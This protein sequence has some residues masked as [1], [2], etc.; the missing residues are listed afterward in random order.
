MNELTEKLDDLNSAI[1][2]LKNEITEA[3]RE[4]LINIEP[5]NAELAGVKR[6]RENTA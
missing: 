5:L 4:A 2:Q 6:K 3:E 1:S